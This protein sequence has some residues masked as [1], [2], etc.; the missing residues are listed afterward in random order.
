MLGSLSLA[1]KDETYQFTRR[2]LSAQFDDHDSVHRRAGGVRAFPGPAV[3]L[4]AQLVEKVHDRLF[5]RV[6][7]GTP[8]DLLGVVQQFFGFRLD[9]DKA[10]S[11]YPDSVTDAV[12]P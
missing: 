3:S 10:N 2:G 12:T 1:G 11:P 6:I 5:R 9:W 4:C 8:G 7:E